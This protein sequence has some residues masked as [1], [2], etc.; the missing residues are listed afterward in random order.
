MLFGVPAKRLLKF[1]LAHLRKDDVFNDHRMTAYSGGHSGSF[2]L[3]LAEDAGDDVSN[4]IE[5][6]D[7]PINN[8]VR[9]KILESQTHQLKLAA[10]PLQFHS[11][12]RTRSDIEAD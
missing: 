4:V 5:F 10:F 1:V 12:N 6:H 2:D 7:L 11:L 9:L 3:V 8:C